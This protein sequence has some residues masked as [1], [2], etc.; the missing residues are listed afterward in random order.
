MLSRVLFVAGFDDTVNDID[1]SFFAKGFPLAT[2]VSCVCRFYSTGVADDLQCRKLGDS[3]ESVRFQAGPGAPF[4]QR[5]LAAEVAL[6]Q[7]ATL[8]RRRDGNKGL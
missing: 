7:H 6:R 1:C 5:F 2:E 8:P 4:A 3:A